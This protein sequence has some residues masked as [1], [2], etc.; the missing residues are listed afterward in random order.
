MAPAG[1]VVPGS[2]SRSL[3]GGDRQQQSQFLTHPCSL[4]DYSGSPVALKYIKRGYTMFFKHGVML[5]LVPLAASLVVSGRAPRT[6]GTALTSLVP[7]LTVLAPA[8]SWSLE[9]C[10]KLE[11]SHGFGWWPSR[12]ISHST[13]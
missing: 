12:L 7:V 5:L 4:A 6:A 11:T 10:I 2:Q 9:T 13:W 1:S 3:A 8:C